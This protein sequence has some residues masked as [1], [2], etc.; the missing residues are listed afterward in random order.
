[1]MTAIGDQLCF[2]QPPDLLVA[3]AVINRRFYIN[4][5]DFV[6]IGVK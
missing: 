6:Y 2:D 1:M 5:P 3:F 4:V